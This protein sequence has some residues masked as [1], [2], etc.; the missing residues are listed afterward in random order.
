MTT[1]AV[2]QSSR[3]PGDQAAVYLSPH[4]DDAALSCGGAIHRRVSLGS[5]VLVITI[6]AGEPAPVPGLP[7][8]QETESS[9]TAAAGPFSSF[10]LVQHAYW[11]NPRRPMALRRAEDMAALTLLG[12]RA[13]HLD[14][15]DAVYRAAPGARWLYT[16]AATLFHTIDPED[17]ITPGSLASSLANLLPPPGEVTLYAPLAIGRHVDHLIVHGAA[18]HLQSLGHRVAYYEDY[19]YAEVPGAVDAA[20]DIAGARGWEEELVSLDPADIAAKVTAVAYYHS[21][22]GVLFDGADEM[23]GRIWSFAATRGAGRLAERLWW[24]N[25]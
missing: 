4:L 22:L 6:F 15:L 19:P 3:K 24:P 8:H 25:G 13:R 21:Q 5:P 23:P 14:Y 16:N 9:P 20:L 17:P 12:A 7:S 2:S 10:A 11:G 1:S 18:R